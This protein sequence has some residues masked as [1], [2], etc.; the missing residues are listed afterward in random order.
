MF[1][2]DSAQE[3]PPKPVDWQL[4]PSKKRKVFFQ[5][6]LIYSSFTFLFL[7]RSIFMALLWLHTLNK[8]PSINNTMVRCFLH[9]KCFKKHKRL[10]E[11][12]LVCPPLLS[13][14]VLRPLLLT[15][16]W[17]WWKKPPRFKGTRGGSAGFYL[18]RRSWAAPASAGRLDLRETTESNRCWAAVCAPVTPMWIK[19]KQEVNKDEW[20]CTVKNC[21]KSKLK[22]SEDFISTIW[23]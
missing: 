4:G 14:L 9:L 2:V 6:L 1:Y 12:E 17:L 7:Y 19:Q 13:E 23:S 21:L 5:I 10:D 8:K 22:M 11:D 16:C 18:W 20:V 15:W 3:G